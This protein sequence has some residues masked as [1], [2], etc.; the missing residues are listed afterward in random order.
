VGCDDKFSAKIDNNK[1][2]K[3]VLNFGMLFAGKL[4]VI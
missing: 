3:A 1:E 2:K 4:Y